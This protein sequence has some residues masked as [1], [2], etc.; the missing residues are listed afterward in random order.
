[1]SRLSQIASLIFHRSRLERVQT[2]LFESRL[3]LKSSCVHLQNDVRDVEELNEEANSSGGKSYFDS[4]I[5]LGD[6]AQEP[7]PILRNGEV[8][9]YKL[10][11]VT[12]QPFRL[13]NTIHDVSCYQRRCFPLIENEL[14]VDQQVLVRGNLF[15]TVHASEDS[16]IR[17]STIRVS[18]INIISNT[19]AQESEV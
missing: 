12:K 4:V 8:I 9:G 6:I 17:N 14:A 11:I 18:T 7:K 3:G 2:S 16:M 15:S 10:K 1:M 19:S 5:V 13:T